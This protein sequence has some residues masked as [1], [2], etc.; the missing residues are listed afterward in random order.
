MLNTLAIFE[1][2]S[3]HL[4]RQAARKIAEILGQVYEEVAETVNKKE[5][6][7][8]KEIVG[9]LA[10]AQNRTEKMLEEL[11]QAQKNLARAQE[12]TERSLNR[13]I[14]DHRQTRERLE[15]MSDAVGYNLENQS[16]KG[17]PPL[18]NVHHPNRHKK[19]LLKIES[20]ISAGSWTVSE[21][22]C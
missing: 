11:A 2:L 12:R 22:G 13:L 17:L 9:D 18:F 7:E 21:G 14:G 10:Q 8:L 4:D 1:D 15:S 19:D 5:F 3:R 6:N 20:G 16:Y